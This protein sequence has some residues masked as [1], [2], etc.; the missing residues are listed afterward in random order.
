MVLFIMVL[1]IMVLFIMVLF[2]G[3]PLGLSYGRDY[4]HSETSCG[5]CV[6]FGLLR[7]L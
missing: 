1:F 5:E 2:K 3:P 4:D 7:D 6:T